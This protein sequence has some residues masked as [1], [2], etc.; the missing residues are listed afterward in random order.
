MAPVRN[1][2]ISSGDVIKPESEMLWFS[3]SI[4]YKKIVA[5]NLNPNKPK[6]KETNAFGL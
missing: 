6:I 4:M 2:K 3:Q 1:P 5:L